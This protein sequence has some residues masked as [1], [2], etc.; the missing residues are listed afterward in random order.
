MERKALMIEYCTLERVYA[1][2][3]ARPLPLEV[4]QGTM[5]LG[6]LRTQPQPQMPPSHNNHQ[7]FQPM[8]QPSQSSSIFV[9]LSAIQRYQQQQRPTEGPGP[10]SSSAPYASPMLPLTSPSFA[11]SGP[12]EVPE[13][14]D[15]KHPSPAAAT[16]NIVL[17]A[18][19]T[20]VVAVRVNPNPER[21]EKYG[22][23]RQRRKRVPAAATPQ[24]IQVIQI[25]A[26]IN[27]LR[28]SLNLSVCLQSTTNIV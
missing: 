15:D 6:Y 17:A 1:E 8:N 26:A 11:S 22:V 24:V 25:C 28:G 10:S 9:P 27:R 21:K 18:V 12:S 5:E 16:A 23:L 19:L 20:A 7:Q 14:N 2:P 4:I 3:D 13:T